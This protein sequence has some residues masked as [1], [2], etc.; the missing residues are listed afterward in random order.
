MV[1]AEAFDNQNSSTKKTPEPKPSFQSPFTHNSKATT[2]Q[3]LPPSALIPGRDNTTRSTELFS[4]SHHRQQNFR[5]A[6][7]VLV[8]ATKQREE[9][10]G[11]SGGLKGVTRFRSVMMS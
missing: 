3:K 2:S 9:R 8:T 6:L 7:D 10:D 5:E 11:R 4:T 1:A